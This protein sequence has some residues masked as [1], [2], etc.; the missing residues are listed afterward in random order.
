MP[1]RRGPDNSVRVSISGTIAGTN[2]ANIFNCQLAT[3]GS[4]AQADLDTW[5]NSFQ[6]AFKTRFQ[7]RQCS[8]VNYTLAR[9]V[10]FTPGGTELVSSVVM[11]GT[12]SNA[13]GVV[14]SAAACAVLSWGTNVYWRGGKPRTYFPGYPAS[15]TDSAHLFNG[16]GLTNWQT[17]GAN[18]R[19]D[20]NALAPASITGTQLGFVSFF[21]GNAP[22]ATPVFF[23]VTAP[24]LHLR[25]GT[26]RRRLGRWVN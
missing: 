13:G 15:D 23:T 12:G 7:P 10:C 26:Q 8:V 22:R 24:K 5:L 20:I 18:F 2:W 17:A 9:A 3:S 4:I 25:V 16:T 11:T 14:S 21:S 19:N 6:A 1:S